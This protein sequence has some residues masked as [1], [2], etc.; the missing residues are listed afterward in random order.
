V[1]GNGNAGRLKNSTSRYQQDFFNLILYSWV[2]AGASLSMSKIVLNPSGVFDTV[3][4]DKLLNA[5]QAILH[6]DAQAIQLNC[7]D[8]SS[9]DTVGLGKLVKILKLVR[10]AG[11]DLE[12]CHVNKSIQTVLTTTELDQIFIIRQYSDESLSLTV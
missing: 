1:W 11:K 5:V 4:A 12:L 2:P 10:R 9:I 7:S 3:E 8:V 6:S